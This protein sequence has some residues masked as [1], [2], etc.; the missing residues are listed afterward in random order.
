MA[1][2]EATKEQV[3]RLQAAV[4]DLQ[5]AS[6][7]RNKQEMELRTCL[8]QVSVEWQ[9][10]TPFL[11]GLR[12]ETRDLYAS[13]VE[14]VQKQ[15][16]KLVRAIN[17]LVKDIYDAIGND[18]PVQTV[19]QTRSRR[20]D[21]PLPSTQAPPSSSPTPGQSAKPDPKQR[22]ESATT[23]ASKDA[24]RQAET[25]SNT[26]EAKAAGSGSKRKKRST[27]ISF[28]DEGQESEILSAG[29]PPFVSADERCSGS[30]R[31]PS[32]QSPEAGPSLLTGPT[33]HLES[34][35]SPLSGRERGTE[36]EG[37]RH[38]NSAQKGSRQGRARGQR[39][40]SESSDD[41][42]SETSSSSESESGKD[43]KKAQASKKRKGKKSKKKSK[44]R[45]DE[46]IADDVLPKT[47]FGQN[48]QK[49]NNHNVPKVSSKRRN[50]LP[51]ERP[52]AVSFRGRGGSVGSYMPDSFANRCAPSGDRR[53]YGPE[54]CKLEFPEHW[55]LPSL[56]EFERE[57]HASR[58]CRYVGPA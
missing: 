37:S 22:K 50:S 58:C 34:P 9:K 44:S 49:T 33:T 14:L 31:L 56:R 10:M 27:E 3:A 42:S 48:K 1:N 20:E 8:A 23:D 36:T 19:S 47:L 32:M 43:R 51:Y 7:R 17:P 2:E 53:M 6:G 18:I 26:G 55:Q 5:A 16:V 46:G 24:Q 39:P 52:A 25:P 41:S 45:K 13:Q 15:A 57:I 35:L 4:Q 21:E 29:S 28:T 11:D 54:F 38:S 30:G 40:E 12:N